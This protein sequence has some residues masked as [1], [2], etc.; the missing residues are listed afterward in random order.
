MRPSGSGDSLMAA[1]PPP[2]SIYPIAEDSESDSQDELLAICD[3]SVNNVT[4]DVAPL[5]GTV[6]NVLDPFNH[7]IE[8]IREKGQDEHV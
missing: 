6:R 4:D 7:A 2:S 1:P 8:V 5:C 3:G